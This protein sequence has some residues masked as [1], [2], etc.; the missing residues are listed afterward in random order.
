M[1]IPQLHQLYLESSGICT[2][3]RNIQRNNL[4]FALS[5]TNFNGNQ[6]A[7]EA[8][9]KG[10]FKAVID[11]EKYSSDNSVLVEDCLITLQALAQ[12]HRRY[13]ALKIISITGSNGKT[14]TKE[15]LTQVLQQKYKVVATKGNLNNH[16]GV[17]LTL[18]G[19]TTET[20]I[21]IVEMG[22]NHQGEIKAL[23][24]IA[25]PNYGFIT[26]FGKAHLEGFGG[27]EGVIRGKSEL[28]D[29]LMANNQTV[30][31]N[32]EDKIQQEKTKDYSKRIS[33]GNNQEADYPINSYTKEF[34][35]C[36][37]YKEKEI[38]SQLTGSYNS[39]NMAA[40]TGIGL[41]FDVKIEKIQ[42]AIKNYIPSN[43]RSQRLDLNGNQIILDAYNANP[44][45]MALAIENIVSLPAKRKI[46]IL[47]DMFEIG[48]TSHKEHQQIVNILETLNVELAL[49]CGEN[50]YK[51]ETEKVLA[52]QQFE[53][54][55]KY[56]SKNSIKDSTIL[57]KGSRGMQ[58]ERLIELWK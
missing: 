37:K 47:G 45:S 27:I 16:I 1:N 57:I 34:Q 19:M 28:Y 56:L 18:L 24:Q 17:P 51:T 22:A 46:L 23:C 48:S 25:E 40:A 53:D 26:N 49:I 33:I 54:L 15:L 5:G 38:S 14:T 21:G 6:F 43:N 41:Y 42:E 12:Y 58:L 35:A 30:F 44:S 52:F 8:L 50:F 10:A 3:T 32:I 36:I 13:L 29:Y 20:E 55:Q 31:M 9:K 11:D 4:F 39:S 2:D 7:A